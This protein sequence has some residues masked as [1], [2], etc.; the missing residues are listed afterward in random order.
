[1]RIIHTLVSLVLAG[2]GLSAGYSTEAL[3]D[4][5]INL[6]GLDSNSIPQFNQFSGYLNFGTKHI[7]YWF[8]EAIESPES[9]PLVFWTN[10]GPGCSGLLG[11]LTEQGPFRPQADGSL[12][13]NKW[14]WNQKAN[15]VFIEQPVGVGFS[16]STNQ[17]DYRIG[18]TQAAQDNVQ[19]ILEFIK[20]FPEYSSAPLYITAESYGGHYIPTWA[21]AIVD[22][23]SANPS[24][25]IKFAG[26]AVGNPYVDY[27]SGVGAQMEAYWDHQLLPSSSWDRYV[28]NGCTDAAGYLNNS[29]CSSLTLDF[30]K[31]IGN[32]NPYALDYP[33]CL[34]AQQVHMLKYLLD[35]LNTDTNT[36]NNLRGKSYLASE[37]DIPY[38]ACEDNWTTE[39]LNRP[40]VI[41][42][43]HVVNSIKWEECSRTTKY[44]L[45]D[46]MKSTIHIYR[47][48]I[49]QKQ[50]PLNMMI[51]SGDDDSV[52]ATK[53][54]NEWVYGLGYPTKSNWVVWV[55]PDNQVAGYKTVFVVPHGNQF[56]FAT[57]HGAGHEVP[58]YKPS[59]AYVLFNSWLGL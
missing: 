9:A 37:P 7:H 8:V 56:Q 42:S 15:M 28:S 38:Q 18:D 35:G 11:F 12:E 25:S 59:Q 57:V 21:D 49:E 14:T 26:F 2:L 20:K 44:E 45:A 43:I 47:K 6:P 46:K 17:S 34:D 16:Y 3:E 27:W 48:L 41:K 51:Y 22:Y 53:Y 10:G 19:V 5:V 36:K 39:Y 31:K 40:D 54:T 29:I 30:M 23:N 55:D 13:Y 32:L 33:V 4:Q 1:M 52:C 50:T 24:N 58:T